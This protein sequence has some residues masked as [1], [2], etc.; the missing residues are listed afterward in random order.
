MENVSCEIFREAL[1][2]RL[3]GEA[4]PVPED[5]VD[6]HLETCAACRSW[7]ERSASLRRSMLV[8]AAPAVPDLT[9]RIMAE[10]PPPPREK[11][12]L[13]VALAL[14]GLVQCGLAF[15]QLL[16]MDTGMHDA[17]GGVMEGHLLNES[18]AW[19]LAV[20]VGLLWAALRTRAASGLLPMITGFVVVLG[21][22]TT[23]DLIGDRV[24][25]ARVLSHTFLVLG[26]ML[27]FAVHRQHRAQHQPGPDLTDAVDTGEETSVQQRGALGLVRPQGKRGRT[28]QR[29]TGRRRAA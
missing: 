29:P 7:Y 16:G 8:R 28:A 11:W 27:L 26:L 20:G 25:A 19:N 1:S 13:R 15:A 5:E 14:V 21:V 2:A 3:D 23:G 18:A 10:T 22:L 6:A 24:T 12:G 17:H 9:A 4:G